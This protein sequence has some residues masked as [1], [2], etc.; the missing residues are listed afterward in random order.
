MVG[1]PGAGKSTCAQARFVAAGYTLINR[2]TIGDMDK[3]QREA[4][5][6]LRRGESVVVDNT[7]PTVQA[8]AKFISLIAELEL[9]GRCGVRACWIRT[10]RAVASALNALRTGTTPK[11]AS[12]KVPAVAINQ[13]YKNFQVPLQ[14]EGFTK[15]VLEVAFKPAFA[16]PGLETKFNRRMAD[17]QRLNDRKAAAEARRA[18]AIN[19]WPSL[20]NK[21]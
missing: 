6:A 11:G 19:G 20:S 2:D 4:R 14:S 7:N 21:S 16:D 8:R 10:D 13:Y 18:V 9:S 17:N 3:C 5:N 1:P 12:R 15:V